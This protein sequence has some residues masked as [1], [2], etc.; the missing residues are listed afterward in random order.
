[1]QSPNQPFNQS[2]PFSYSSAPV[3]V[4]DSPVEARMAFIRKT[5]VLFLAGILCCMLAGVATLYSPA[6]LGASF[7]VLRMPLLAFILIIGAS[8]GAQAVSRIEGVNYFALFGFTGLLG[9]L[10]TRSSRSTSSRN[11]AS[12]RKR[13]P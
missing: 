13:R 1:M 7:A 5:Y 12:S 4:A 9:W 2:N 3:S 10:F 6:L 11:P 8:M